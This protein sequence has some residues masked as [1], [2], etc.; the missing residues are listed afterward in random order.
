[1]IG[2][3]FWVLGSEVVIPRHCLFFNKMLDTGYW[4]GDVFYLFYIY[5]LHDESQDVN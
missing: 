2:S 3:R 4:I 5:L 1:M